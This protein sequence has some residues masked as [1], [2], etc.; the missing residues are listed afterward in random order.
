[1]SAEFPPQEN[2]AKK[3]YTGTI[4]KINTFIRTLED[5]LDTVSVIEPQIEAVLD[6]LSGPYDPNIEQLETLLEQTQLKLGHTLFSNKVMT[7][8]RAVLTRERWNEYHTKSSMY[9]ERMEALVDEIFETL[10]AIKDEINSNPK[11]REVVEI[12]NKPFSEQSAVEKLRVKIAQAQAQLDL[13][14][15][16]TT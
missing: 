1:M 2:T 15:K 5:E 14:D 16:M 9:N 8:L 6:S 4:E 10:P 12:L 3:A 7:K 13:I 11:W